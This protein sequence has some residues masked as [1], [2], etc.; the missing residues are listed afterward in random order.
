MAV[1][2]DFR[3]DLIRILPNLRAFAISLTGRPDYA[4][5][6]VQ[7][8]IIRA[9]TQFESFEPGSNLK[10]WLFTILRNEYFSQIRKTKREVEDP[11]GIHAG[12]LVES[13]SQHGMMDLDDFKQAL[14]KLPDD[15]REAVI[16][17]G[18]SGFTYEEAAEICAVAPG[19]I[20]SRVSRA[21]VSLV[22]L[23]GLSDDDDFNPAALTAGILPQ[24]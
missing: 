21:R 23:L 2:D 16:L 14:D 3:D 5:D 15:Q 7:E 18:A 1:P 12:Q 10:A 24:G 17:V 8:T 4:D 11:D 13:P 9:W 20:K 22:E 6:I 19:T